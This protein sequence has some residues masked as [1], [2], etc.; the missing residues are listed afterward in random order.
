MIVMIG[1][2]ATYPASIWALIPL[3]GAAGAIVR[4]ALVARPY[5]CLSAVS[6][7]N[8][9]LFLVKWSLDANGRLQRQGDSGDKQAGRAQI[10]NAVAVSQGGNAPVVTPVR[11]GRPS[12]LLV[13]W[14]DRPANG[15]LI[16]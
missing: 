16:L 12:L 3:T 13:S 15:E 7:S 5:G 11:S 6:D 8:Q 14:D 1:L 4:N 2:V 10:V 9:N